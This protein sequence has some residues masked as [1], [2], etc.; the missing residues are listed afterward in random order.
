MP[1]AALARW[2]LLW[3]VAL[4]GHGRVPL[5]LL[6]APWTAQPNSPE[7]YLEPAPAAAWVAAQVGQADAP[8]LGVMIDRLGAADQPEWLDGDLV[9]AVAA[10]TGERFGYDLAA[11]RHW[12]GRNRPDGR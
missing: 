5:E 10:L 7:K 11:W 1:A 4:N 12:W 6:T 2:Y 9:G 3:A 8:T